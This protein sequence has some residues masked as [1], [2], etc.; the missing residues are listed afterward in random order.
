LIGLAGLGTAVGFGILGGRFLE[1]IARQPELRPLLLINF[2]IMAAFVDAMAVISIGMGLY[3]MFAT[4]PFMQ[5]VVVA[6]KAHT[7]A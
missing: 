5:A 4:N 6:A 1:G 3:L 2:F 7:G